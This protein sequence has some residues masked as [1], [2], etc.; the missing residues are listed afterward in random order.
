MTHQIEK[1]VYQIFELVMKNPESII[2]DLVRKMN[3]TKSGNHSI[4]DWL[5]IMSK[6]T[7]TSN[8]DLK[9]KIDTNILNDD[10]EENMISDLI[11]EEVIENLEDLCADDLDICDL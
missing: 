10:E 11:E 6:K 3:N 8:N 5:N 4:K 1:P 7:D 2:A 9:K